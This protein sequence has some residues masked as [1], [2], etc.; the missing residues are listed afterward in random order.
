MFH[1]QLIV[2]MAHFNWDLISFLNF[3]SSFL[4]ILF[5]SK[6]GFHYIALADLELFVNQAVLK[7]TEIHQL[8]PPEFWD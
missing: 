8:L 1:I 4:P 5:L 6:T 7:L 3:F 2:L